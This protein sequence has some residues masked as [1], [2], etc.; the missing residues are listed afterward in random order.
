MPLIWQQILEFCAVFPEPILFGFDVACIDQRW[1]PVAAL[2]VGRQA[3]IF[4]KATGVAIWLSQSGIDAAPVGGEGS[5]R[6]VEEE[7]TR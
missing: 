5:E 3:G 4:K 6:F 7:T 1:G 2:E